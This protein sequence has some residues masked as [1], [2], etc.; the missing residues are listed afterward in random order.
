MEYRELSEFT[1]ITTGDEVCIIGIGM[2]GQ[3][4]L[5]WVAVPHRWYG[6]TLHQLTMHLEDLSIPGMLIIRRK[7]I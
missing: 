4:I 5:T 2:R 1:N 3:P 6:L 7:S